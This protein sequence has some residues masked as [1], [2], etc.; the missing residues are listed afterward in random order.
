MPTHHRPGTTPTPDSKQLSSNYQKPDFGINKRINFISLSS[1]SSL[2]DLSQLAQR[3]HLKRTRSISPG[4]SSSSSSSSS[5]YGSI[6]SAD[7]EDQ[8]QATLDHQPQKNDHVS[9]SG[10][11]DLSNNS[12]DHQGAKL[13]M[14]NKGMQLLL[15]MGWIQG[16]GLGV[17]QKGRK[18]PIPTPAQTPLLGLGK[19]TQ[20]AY[21]L[22]NAI[23]KPKELESII[24]ARETEEDKIK[25]EE[26]VKEVQ[27]RV[28]ERED[29]LKTFHCQVC[30]K[31]YTTISQFEEH[32]R[33]YAH[34]HAKRALEARE[35][36]KA[37]GRS[38]EAKLEKERKRE[39]KELERMA[40][41]AGMTLDARPSVSVK[42][43]LPKPVSAGF[44]NS[45]AGWAK[46]PGPAA[47]LSTGQNQGPSADSGMGPSLP[48]DGNKHN[49]NF[50]PSGF[51]KAS[52]FAPISSS[53]T[54]GFKP[55]G[56]PS[57][58]STPTP[59][60][61]SSSSSSSGPLARLPPV[62]IASSSAETSFKPT[63]EQPPEGPRSADDRPA[64]LPASSA[65]SAVQPPSKFA[66]IAAR[67]A[68]R[69]A[70][71]AAASSHS[72]PSNSNKAEQ[73]SKAASY[74]SEVE[75]MLDL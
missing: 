62:F 44:K 47:T 54:S 12:S 49:N 69:K 16:N 8:K 17:G 34:H 56:G 36:R 38:T 31:G 59:T 67:L 27:T 63:R 23:S 75:K 25:R 57:A 1:M 10:K 39:A 65:P 32:E 74:H 70:A 53:L 61:R 29:R 71:A 42:P 40:R 28:V 18:E 2:N 52:G 21:M 45:T 14:D 13:G 6:L 68:A 43:A 51:K 30:D 41:A 24:I 50:K 11:Q 72:D 4:S 58:A 33:S 48:L 35:S 19:A 64:P 46:L 7:E 26:K 5:G 9:H 22:S 20:D 15:K 73:P 37:I 3:Y 60:V 55:I 66:Q